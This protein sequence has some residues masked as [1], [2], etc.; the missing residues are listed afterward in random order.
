MTL[1][2]ECPFC[3]GAGRVHSPGHNGDPMDMG[4]DCPRCEG[5]GVIAVDLNEEMEE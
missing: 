3:D 1:E 4:E 5:A 2:Q